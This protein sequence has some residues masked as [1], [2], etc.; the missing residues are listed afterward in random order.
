[1]ANAVQVPAASQRRKALASVQR[2]IL[3]RPIRVLVYGAEKVGKSTFAAGAPS[4]V[5]IGAESGTEN[6]D[7]ARL[8]PTNWEE[9]LG[10][11]HDFAT[12]SH[13]YKTLVLD[14]I[15]WLEPLVWASVC[16]CSPENA[17]SAIE[18]YG[19]GY[20]KGY[21][22]ALGPWRE[23][24]A[25]L[26]KCW[27]RGMHIIL[28]AHQQ[29]KNFKNPTGPAYDRYELAMHHKAAGILKQWV[30]GVL[31]AELETFTTVDKRTKRVTGQ[32]SGARILHTTPAAAYDAGNR[33]GLPE[34]LPLSWESF[35]EAIR[36]GEARTADLLAQIESLFAQLDDPKI[37]AVSKDWLEKNKTNADR[38]AEFVNRLNL[39]LEEKKATVAA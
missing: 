7:V 26:E 16:Q 8:Q 14:P 4:P 12:E 35:S 11:V 37:R 6:L 28:S 36:S 2:G 29:V 20:M 3:Q 25:A 32:S 30:A 1:M 22:A 13:E 19:G 38:L 15:N 33:W 27:M 23:L 18:E 24:L 5:F 21:E 10:W 17:S 9:A 34:E 39:K 31:F